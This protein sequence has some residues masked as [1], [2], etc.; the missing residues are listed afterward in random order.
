MTPKKTRIDEIKDLL[1]R[2]SYKYYTLDKPSVSDAVYDSLMDELK[3]IES[4]H[5]ELI[6][7]IIVT[8]PGM[9]PFHAL[10]FSDCYRD[11]ETRSEERRVGKEC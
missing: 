1:N 4:D 6:T 5:P 10:R 8:L 7:M 9:Y 3:K 11:W 2:Y